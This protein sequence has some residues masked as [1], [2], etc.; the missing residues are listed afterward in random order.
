MF[1][2][3]CRIESTEVFASLPNPGRLLELLLPNADVYLEKNSSKTRR[4]QYTLVAVNRNNKPILL[5]THKTN[6]VAEY[7]LRNNLIPE[8]KGTQII[9]REATLGNSRFD[10]LL[11]LDDK[12]TYLEVK[13]CTL[14]RDNV[15]MFPDAV[16][17]RGKKHITELAKLYSS[18]DKQGAV[19]FIVHTDDVDIFLPEYHI[20]PKFTLALL[21]VKDKIKV[22]AAAVTYDNSL[23]LNHKVKTLNIP[24]T[25]VERIK[26]KNRR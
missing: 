7:L 20:D 2:V 11:R 9:K 6:D 17:L 15:A 21:N 19:L 16:T 18:K 4:F 14:F 3:K 13:S 23:S 5:H 26:I 10:F 22:I 1:V 12:N 24:W 8:L 25:I